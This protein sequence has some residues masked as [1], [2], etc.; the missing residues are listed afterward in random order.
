MKECSDKD[1]SITFMFTDNQ[2][3]DELFLE[4][5]NNLLNSGQIPNLWEI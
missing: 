1:Q 2:I 5:I 3:V 4:D